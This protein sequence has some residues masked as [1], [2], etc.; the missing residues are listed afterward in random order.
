M[1]YTTPEVLNCW[2]PNFGSVN[3]NS[4]IDLYVASEK[5]KAIPSFTTVE[6]VV[7]PFTGAPARYIYQQGYI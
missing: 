3:G 2:Q 5:L 4:N 7:E 1:L 6:Q